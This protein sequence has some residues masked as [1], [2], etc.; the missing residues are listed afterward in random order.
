MNLIGN[1][2]IA[3]YITRDCIKQ[4]FSNPFTWCIMDFESCFNLVKYY[5]EI[6]FTHFKLQ[7]DDRW[8]F[9]IIIDDLVKVQYVHYHF[10]PNV[11]KVIIKNNDVFS[12]NIWIYI[13][14]KYISRTKRMLEL[15]EPPTFI[16]ATANYGLARHI[17]FT[18]EQQNKLLSLRSPYKIILSFKE[19]TTLPGCCIIDQNCAFLDN[20]PKLSNYIYEKM[21]TTPLLA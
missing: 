19:N 13:T 17:P 2:C 4:Q 12:N 3:S 21:K 10:D 7:H 6:N 16:F 8:I 1:S 20:G 11:S 14:N 18:I 5:D 9:S 15:K